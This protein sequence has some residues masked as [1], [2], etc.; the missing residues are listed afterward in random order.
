M[1]S[2]FV[3]F[4]HRFYW[5]IYKTRTLSGARL[6]PGGRTSE[7][8]TGID[9]QAIGVPN[10]VPK[11]ARFFRVLAGNGIAP[12]TSMAVTGPSLL[13]VVHDIGQRFDGNRDGV[14]KGTEKWAFIGELATRLAPLIEQ[15]PATVTQNTEAAP[16]TVTGLIGSAELAPGGNSAD[17]IDLST[18]NWLNTNVSDWAQ[19]STITRVNIG[20][21]PIGIEHTK[22]GQWPSITAGGT[23]VEGNPWILANIDGE[24][25]AATYEWLR[26][27]QTEKQISAENIG[28]NTKKPP[29]DGWQPKSGDTV[30]LMVST[31]A[32]F[33]PEG[34]INERSNVVLVTWP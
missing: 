1:L 5:C 33:G 20:S 8:P 22:A 18:V 12:R 7:L 26:P 11:M 6:G 4:L 28:A 29:L 2:F 3:R 30:G 27:G 17:Q 24:W 19:T 25:Y 32:R 31:P 13:N 9:A 21:P 34:P 16:G 10:A 14:I 23:V 15:S